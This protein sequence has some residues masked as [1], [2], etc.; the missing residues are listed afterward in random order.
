M[1]F[2]LLL[3]AILVSAGVILSAPYTAVARAGLRDTFPGNFAT[4]VG[5]IVGALVLSA[6]VFALT[7]I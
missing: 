3:Q 7:R 1:N 2:A 6:L 4:V 5:G